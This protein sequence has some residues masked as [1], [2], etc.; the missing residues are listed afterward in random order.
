MQCVT[1]DLFRL[2]VLSHH[3]IEST[4]TDPNSPD[5]RLVLWQRDAAESA[6]D[7]QIKSLD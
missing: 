5:N 2:V 3:L 1:A 6:I 4:V 7:L